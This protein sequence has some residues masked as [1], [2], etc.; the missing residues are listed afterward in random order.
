[1][2]ECET[3]EFDFETGI[4]SLKLDEKESVIVH[5]HEGI[6]GVIA[7]EEE[8]RSWCVDTQAI[9]R[10]QDRERDRERTAQYGVARVCSVVAPCAA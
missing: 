2:S 9:A 4:E 6:T 3:A 5:V 8:Y 7:L 1:M 10:N